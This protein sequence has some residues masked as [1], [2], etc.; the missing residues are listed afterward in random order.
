[1]SAL[2]SSG[3]AVDLVLG[4]IALEAAGLLFWRWRRGRGP[5]A[6]AVFGLLAPGALILLA[7]RAALVGAAV[8]WIALFLAASFPV[9]LLDVSLRLRGA[10]QTQTH[11]EGP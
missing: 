3:R 11:Q 7:L 1:M 6:L 10:S 5:G 9:H 4:I 8:E 2:F